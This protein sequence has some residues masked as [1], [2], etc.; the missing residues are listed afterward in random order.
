MV[1]FFI[2]SV[3]LTNALVAFIDLMNQVFHQFMDLFIIVFIYNILICSNNEVDHADHLYTMVHTLKDKSLYVKFSK[4]EF[5]LNT[6]TF[7]IMLY[8]PK[9][10]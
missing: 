8:L 7:S 1:K 4:C 3:G 9:G 2:M 6:V 5:W 10:L